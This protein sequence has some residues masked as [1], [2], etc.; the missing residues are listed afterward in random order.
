MEELLNEMKKA[1][2]AM[3]EAGMPIQHRQS[4]HNAIHH[5]QKIANRHQPVIAEKAT[6][7]CGKCMYL[8]PCPTMSPGAK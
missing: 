4:V 7:R 8:Y 3:R 2:I 6:T 1:L 5:L